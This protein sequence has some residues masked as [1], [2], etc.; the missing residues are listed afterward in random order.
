MKKMLKSKTKFIRIAGFVTLALV[1]AGLAFA[2]YR[3]GLAPFPGKGSQLFGAVLTSASKKASAPV[4]DI[5]EKQTAQVTTQSAATR[6]ADLLT[7]LLDMTTATSST[8]IRGPLTRD[9][10]QNARFDI[11]KKADYTMFI[12]SACKDTL[13]LYDNGVA[14]PDKPQQ[15]PLAWAVRF[16]IVIN[17][18][19]THTFQSKCTVDSKELHSNPIVITTV[20]KCGDGR[21]DGSEVCDDRNATAGDGCSASCV[22]EDGFECPVVGSPCNAICGDGKKKGLELCDNGSANTTNYTSSLL[23]TPPSPLPCSGGSNKCLA[24]GSYCGDG[25]VNVQEQCDRD[26][27][28]N[29]VFL[30]NA[31]CATATFNFLKGGTLKCANNCSY[32]TSGCSIPTVC[33]DGKTEGAEVCDD[34]NTVDET[35]CAYGQ[36]CT[37]CKSDCT[38]ALTIVGPRCGDNTIN[39]SETCDGSVPGGKTCATEVGTGSTGTLSCASS[40]TLNKSACSAVPRCG[41]SIVQ[42]DRGET[43]DDNN[44]T[45]E[46]CAYGQASCTVCDSACHTVAGAVV[47]RCGDGTIQSANGEVCDGIILSGQT[48]P[49]GLYGTPICSADCHSV[50]TSAC[51]ALSITNC[52]NTVLA[53]LDTAG[54]YTTLHLNAHPNALIKGGGG[55]VGAI[56]TWKL[57]GNVVKSST[58]NFVKL[59]NMPAGTTTVPVQHILILNGG[60]TCTF[61]VEAY[62][63]ADPGTASAKVGK[64]SPALLLLYDWNGSGTITSTPV[65]S[66]GIEKNDYIGISDFL[67]RKYT[68]TCP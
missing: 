6:I 14:L 5:K 45:T 56:Y 49:T 2:S 60:P 39:G 18:L 53:A 19:G 59:F 42:S 36:T 3:G 30:A 55:A 35:T 16:Y 17:S 34:G 27:N 65:C 24:Y 9:V 44:T 43:C 20:A 25:I 64:T 11:L 68:L 38:Q 31:S 33:G 8:Y 51:S 50:S 52:P 21:K 37:G 23:D 47:G 29:F 67:Q 62:T 28:G 54:G 40:C 22:I 10:G 63:G 1:V 48:C 26:L 13:V 12:D 58:D 61:N 4:I 57:D 66:P 32:D 41:D 7:E 46:T 15:D